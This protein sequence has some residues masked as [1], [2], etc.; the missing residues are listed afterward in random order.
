[1]KAT[2]AMLL[3]D[4]APDAETAMRIGELVG[5][6]WEVHRDLVQHIAF[7]LHRRGEQQ[8]REIEEDDLRRLLETEATY[9]PLAN[10]FIA[11]TRLRGT[12]L[13]ERLRRYRFLHL[14]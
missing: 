11:L 9:A 10:D 12:L 13:E 2:D 14:A 8:G 3:P 1:M 5:G 4:Y 7:Y 6:S